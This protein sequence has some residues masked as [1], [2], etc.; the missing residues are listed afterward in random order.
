MRFQNKFWGFICIFL[1]FAGPVAAQYGVYESPYLNMRNEDTNIVIEIPA[2][3]ENDTGKLIEIK[4]NGTKIISTHIY[5]Y[6]DLSDS[7]EELNLN[8]HSYGDHYPS[9]HN[10]PPED[11]P[12]KY[13]PHKESNMIIYP[14]PGQGIF[15]IRAEFPAEEALIIKI[16]NSD[17]GLISSKTI[18]ADYAGI[19][20]EKINISDM[21]SGLYYIGLILRTSCIW[22]PYMLTK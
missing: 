14:N 12:I 8:K 17:G 6:L 9:T 19:L 15:E 10:A 7:I 4:G 13:L 22:Q 21:A 16:I 20:S 5:D 3:P 1:G 18:N 2:K 11:I